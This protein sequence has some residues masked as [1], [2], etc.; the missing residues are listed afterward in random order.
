VT[1]VDVKNA[2][3]AGDP[4]A[5]LDETEEVKTH[6]GVVIV[7]GLSRGEVLKLNGAR[8][9]GDLD[10]AEWEQALVSKGIVTPAMTAAE[11]AKWQGVEV[12]GGA[13]KDVTDAIVR[14]SKLDEG[15]S[16]SGVRGTRGRARSRV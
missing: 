15:A 6:A 5:P 4:E 7:R 12:A 14:L 9:R 2:L 16:K 13:L 10:V 3:L 8:D 1:D 11:V